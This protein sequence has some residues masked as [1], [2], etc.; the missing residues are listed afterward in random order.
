MCKVSILMPVYNASAYLQEA[1]ESIINQTFTDWELIIINDGSTDKSAEICKYFNDTRIRYF[2]HKENCKLI[3]T[4]NEG[5]D[6]CK[7]Q[8]I[9]RMDADD[10]S[11]PKRL[12]KQLAFLEN[13]PD[14]ILVGTNAYVIDQHE[15]IIGKI[16]N[17][18][19]NNFLQVSLLFTTPFVHPSIMIRTHILKQNKYSTQY[20]HSEDQE[21]WMRI[22]CLGKIANLKS[23]LFKYRIHN[24]NVSVQHQLL[25]QQNSYSLIS[26][27]LKDLDII[28][29]K[30]ELK[31][32]KLSFE[33]FE[34]KI[35]NQAVNNTWKSTE[36]ELRA[37]FTFLIKKNK[38]KNRYQDSNLQA[39]LWSRWT[40]FCLYHKKYLRAL[41]PGFVSIRLSIFTYYI[42]LVL[43]LIKKK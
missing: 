43:Y 30:R 13:N 34:S 29:S 27:G 14:Y 10:I 24:T 3:A 26:N 42:Q 40:V 36:K 5:I 2:E 4:L 9:A 32:H 7:G 35:G 23:M 20:I 21:L 15:K 28:P 33:L 1:I 19:S 31:L 25:Q 8:Y 38:E 6:L 11:M 39:F 22:A 37:W 12:E 41:S 18:E 17:P 16:I